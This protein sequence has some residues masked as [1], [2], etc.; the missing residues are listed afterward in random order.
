VHL[1]KPMTTTLRSAKE[2]RKNDIT[3]VHR[4]G[5]YSAI[6]PP[7]GV[8]PSD[9]PTDMTDAMA[10]LFFYAGSKTRLSAPLDLSGRDPAEALLLT[11]VQANMTVQVMVGMSPIGEENTLRILAKLLQQGTIALVD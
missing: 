6:R 11:F 10:L 7:R 8:A 5:T 1:K 2:L 3:E 9:A 4:S